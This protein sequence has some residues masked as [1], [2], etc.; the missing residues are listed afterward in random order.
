MKFAFNVEN[1]KISIRLYAERLDWR[2]GLKRDNLRVLCDSFT[3][4]LEGIFLD[5]K[6]SEQ[7]FT[8][9]FHILCLFVAVLGTWV[10]TV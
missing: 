5:D 2:R 4:I 10:E 6:Y 8:S 9:I 7:C 1:N 3:F